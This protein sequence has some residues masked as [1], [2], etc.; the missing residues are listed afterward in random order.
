MNKR[1]SDVQ[2]PCTPRVRVP[3]HP[4]DQFLKLE[5]V[6]ERMPTWAYR[7]SMETSAELIRDW[8]SGDLSVR[9][10]AVP[11]EAV[12]E[13]R[14][15][16][17]FGSRGESEEHKFLKAIGEAWMRL[18]GYEDVDMEVMSGG[19][20]F[21]VASPRGAWFIEVGNTYQDK[22]TK[23]IFRREPC[24]LTIIPYTASLL[25]MRAGARRHLFGFDF[26]YRADRLEALRSE[27]REGIRR[28]VLGP[29][30]VLEA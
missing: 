28:A 26:A 12:A 10:V 21:D 19:S 16:R 18:E 2:N 3:A 8:A 30:H 20:R 1:P 22:V 23:L 4:F 5:R 14:R 9:P 13:A 25:A 29:R 7:N 24:R 17:V 6:L 15:V 27:H 11:E